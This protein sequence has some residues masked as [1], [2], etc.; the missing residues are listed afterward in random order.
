[1]AKARTVVSLSAQLVLLLM[2]AAAFFL[3][4]PQVAGLSMEPRVH[5]GEFVLINTLA[6]RFAPIRR[7]D[8]VA[9]LHDAPNPETYIKRVVGLPGERVEVRAGT[10]LVNGRALDEPYVRFRDRRSAPAV[11]VPAGTY[12]VLGDNRAD[13]DDSRDWGVLSG[14]DVSGRAVV[15]I[16]P[17]RRL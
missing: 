8:V 16:W 3:R 4:T 7:G 9:F 12:Y 5:A 1:M 2:I 13:S 14:R 17:P 11:V 10:V 15:G 6:Y